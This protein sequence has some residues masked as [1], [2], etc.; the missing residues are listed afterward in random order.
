MK[1]ESNENQDNS[2]IASIEVG[3]DSP[4]LV[5]DDNFETSHQMSM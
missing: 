5:E 1:A 2:S 3:A 4:T